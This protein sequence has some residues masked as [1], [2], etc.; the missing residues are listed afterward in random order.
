MNPSTKERIDLIRKNLKTEQNVHIHNVIKVDVAKLRLAFEQDVNAYLDEIEA[1]GC[2]EAVADELTFAEQMLNET[3]KTLD[4]LPADE[5]LDFIKENII[6]FIN[7]FENWELEDESFLV[8][9]SMDK[10]KILKAEERLVTQFGFTVALFNDRKYDLL[11]TFLWAIAYMEVSY[12]DSLEDDDIEDVETTIDDDVHDELFESST[13]YQF[14]S[15][16]DLEDDTPMKFLNEVSC[17]FSKVELK[18]YLLSAYWK[19]ATTIVAFNGSLLEMRRLSKDLE[20]AFKVINNIHNESPKQMRQNIYDNLDDVVKVYQDWIEDF[21]DFPAL[22]VTS[23]SCVNLI[24]V[25]EEENNN[26]KRTM[27]E[28]NNK[29]D[30]IVY[31]NAVY[32][33]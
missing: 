5:K 19:E 28:L 2:H 32:Y 22:D 7:M 21:D 26:F 3:L 14:V 9:G 33:G 17:L 23:E 15:Q 16:L 12:L 31:L 4:E 10:E 30:F 20:F 11:T 25:M 13:I 18:Q 6:K 27:R 8:R 24:E 29:W 1:F